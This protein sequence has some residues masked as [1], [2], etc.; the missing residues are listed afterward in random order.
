[1]PHS[2]TPDVSAN[3]DS[4]IGDRPFD[5]AFQAV[6]EIA[7]RWNVPWM[8][9]RRW[10]DHLV[11]A[12][13]HKFGPFRLFP[14]P[15]VD[16]SVNPNFPWRTPWQ[17]L[18]RPMNARRYFL[19]YPWFSPGDVISRYRKSAQMRFYMAFVMWF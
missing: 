2:S 5:S 6:P 3:G 18:Y 12:H 9:H 17:W 16:I 19:R 1:M 8:M 4:L 15:I 13:H 7:A 14:E 10:I 11:H